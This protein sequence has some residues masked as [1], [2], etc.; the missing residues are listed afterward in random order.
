MNDSLHP[1]L[2]WITSPVFQFPKLS[3]DPEQRHMCFLEKGYCKALCDFLFEQFIQNSFGPTPPCTKYNQEVIDLCQPAM[4]KRSEE[5]SS[6]KRCFFLPSFLCCL[7]LYKKGKKTTFH[8]FHIHF[9]SYLRHGLLS[10]SFTLVLTSWQLISAGHASPPSSTRPSIWFS[11]LLSSAQPQNKPMA[12][13][14]SVIIDVFC[15]THSHSWCGGQFSL[16]WECQ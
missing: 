7:F 11:F 9:L 10:L 15:T 1:N 12:S 13:A 8:F 5:H 14:L 6:P 4:Q 2:A 3:S 16:H